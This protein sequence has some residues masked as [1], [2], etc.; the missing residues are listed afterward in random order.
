M[1]CS[2]RNFVCWHQG[3]QSMTQ[4]CGMLEMKEQRDA[5]L[6]SLCRFTLTDAAD[7]DHLLGHRNEAGATASGE[8]SS[9]VAVRSCGVLTT[10][11]FTI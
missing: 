6:T 11:P 8:L 4:A 10:K 5:F 2:L 1:R 9:P 3:Y 7:A